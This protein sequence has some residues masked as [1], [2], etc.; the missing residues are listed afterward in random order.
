M[1]ARRALPLLLC[2]APAAAQGALVRGPVRPRQLAQLGA[3]SDGIV[4]RILV[5]EGERVTRGQPLLQLDDEV[6]RA[7]VAMARQ[8][9]EAEGDLRQAQAAAAEAAAHAGRVG[10]AAQRGGAM[11][12]ESQA[13]AARAA[14]ARAAVDAAE[15]RRRLERRRLELAQ[16]E[17]EL[18]VI[19][20]PFDGR[21]FRVET[22]V[23]SP[24]ARADRPI[25]VADLRELEAVLY[26][27][28]AGIARLSEG[29][30][31][32]LRLGAP[33][34]RAVMSQ[35]RHIDRLMDAASGRFRC[36]FAIANPDEAIPAGV[37]AELDLD[38]LRHG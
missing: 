2:A 4:Q 30:R 34:G 25:T 15:D 29:A 5:V 26:V 13:A 36:I 10:A 1:I 37:E 32:P 20:A 18:L 8:A 21:V 24:L 17:A 11:A 14:T 33:V 12:W 22:T 7:R 31:A 38:M 16:A 23:G 9:A 35:L 3:L 27:P 19:R 6:Q 28:A